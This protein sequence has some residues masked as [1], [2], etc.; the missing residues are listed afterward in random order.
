MSG[1]S[2]RRTIDSN[3]RHHPNARSNDGDIAELERRL[4]LL[5]ETIETI[6]ELD[7]PAPD[8]FGHCPAALMAHRSSAWLPL[9]A[10][11]VPRQRIRAL[12]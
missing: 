4:R 8:R 2:E 1:S 12:K 5:G 7:E 6:T 9:D 10:R 3:T 11:M